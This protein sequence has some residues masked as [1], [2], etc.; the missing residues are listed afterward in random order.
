LDALTVASERRDIQQ[1]NFPHVLYPL[2]G[3]AYDAAMDDLDA[4]D[5]DRTEASVALARERHP[6]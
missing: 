4:A 1:R 3:E 6:S 5:D 2:G